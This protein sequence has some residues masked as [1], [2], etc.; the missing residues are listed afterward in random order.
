MM[1]PGFAEIARAIHGVSG[2]ALSPDKGYL[3]KTRLAP[4]MERRGLANLSELARRLPTADGPVLLRE[5]AEATTTNET[6]FF[7]DGL[8]LRQI[9]DQVLPVL[10]AT[11]PP[12]TPLRIWSAACSSGQEAYSLAIAAAEAGIARRLDI[13]GTDLCSAMVSRAREGLFTRFEVERGLTPAQR[14]RWFR[15]ERGGWRVAEPIRRQ[16][17]FEV[18]NLLGDLRGLGTFDVLLL[19]NVLIYFDLP[20][21][22]KVVTACTAQ[23]A[24]DGALCLGATETLLGLTVPLVPLPGLRGLW[25]RG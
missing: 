11:H 18:A 19:R 10:D 21:R 25:R 22:Q 1:D 5:L 24:M 8:P 13:L 6:S 17:R 4:I 23:L 7:R 9:V 2:L 14:S 20:T 15:E 12:G 3:L 16:C